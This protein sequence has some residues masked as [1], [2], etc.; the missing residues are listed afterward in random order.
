MSAGRFGRQEILPAGQS[1]ERTGSKG[2]AGRN[3]GV[4]KEVRG[5]LFERDNLDTI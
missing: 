5:D 4:E 3:T 2:A 1:G